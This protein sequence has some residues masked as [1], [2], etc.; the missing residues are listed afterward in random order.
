MPRILV[1]ECKQEVSSFNPVLSG[2]EDFAISF[3]AEI[4][5]FHQGVGSE[6]GGALSVFRQRSD[7]EIVPGYS[8]RSI[9]SGGT[10][11]D[12]GLRRIA[13]EFLDAV[14]KARDVDAI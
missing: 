11:A 6:M 12:V 14:R 10:L 13:A 3:G 4:L 8:A 1:N 2:Y 9:T 7:I 5:R